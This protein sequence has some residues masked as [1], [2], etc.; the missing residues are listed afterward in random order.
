MN[1]A[2]KLDIDNIPL[3]E[4]ITNVS[5]EILVVLKII[6]HCRQNTQSET[7]T[8]Q[9][10]GL[11]IRGELEVTDCFP[12]PLRHDDEEDRGSAHALEMMKIIRDTVDNNTVGWYYS[13]FLEAHISQFLLETQFS[14]QSQTTSSVVL[15]YDPLVTTQGTLGFR[16]YRLSEAFMDLH[17]GSGFTKESLTSH[18]FKFHDIFV[19]IPITIRTAFGYTDA[20]LAQFQTSRDLTS[21]YEELEMGSEFLNKNLEGLLY[22]ISD[23]Q[24]EQ[25]VYDTYQRNMTKLEKEQQQYI[26]RRKH[27]NEIR[28]SKGEPLLSEN[29]R[30][31]EIEQPSLFK[32][33]PEPSRLESLLIS[34]RMDSHCDQL[35]RYTGM[36]AERQNVMRAV[37]ESV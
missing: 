15:I 6:Q 14:Y 23:L 12:L 9:L 16:A 3:G 18:K 28:K 10:L 13:G 29:H 26:L 32:K 4:S 21:R 36:Q 25:T 30:D 31:F 7:V 5:L 8:G 11:D 22:C 24:K 1:L 35:L 37:K 27:E 33:P 2:N 19:N 20:L 17:R 34:N